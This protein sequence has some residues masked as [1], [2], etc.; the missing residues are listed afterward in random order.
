MPNTT[1]STQDT[2]PTARPG[3]AFT[4]T[5]HGWVHTGVTARATTYRRT[6]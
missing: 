1:T 3:I 6:R 4:Q 2:T 5:A